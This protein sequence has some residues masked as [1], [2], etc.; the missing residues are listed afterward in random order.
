MF[1]S[2]PTKFCR[3][4][5]GD[6]TGFDLPK[7]VIYCRTTYSIHWSF[8][9]VGLIL[10]PLKNDARI[11]V[12]LKYENKFQ[13][14]LHCTAIIPNYKASWSDVF[15]FSSYNINKYQCS[16]LQWSL[17]S[18]TG[19]FVIFNKIAKGSKKLNDSWPNDCSEFHQI[20]W[21]NCIIMNHYLL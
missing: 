20:V 11:I 18:L 3:Y 1:I 10:L 4:I 17:L 8:S 14:K 16:V 5:N 19:C 2:N 15:D 6:F 13:P 12:R 9:V 7:Y 21:Q